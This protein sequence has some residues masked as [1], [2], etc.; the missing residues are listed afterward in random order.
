ME[1]VKDKIDTDVEITV[2]RILT[3]LETG[4]EVVDTNMFAYTQPIELAFEKAKK[5]EFLKDPRIN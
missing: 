1:N 5:L 4:K 3:A 2:K